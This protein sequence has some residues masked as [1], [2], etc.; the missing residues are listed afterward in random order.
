MST[1]NDY[2]RQFSRYADKTGKPEKSAETGYDRQFS[3]YADKSQPTGNSTRKRSRALRVSLLAAGCVLLSLCAVLA[4]VCIHQKTHPVTLVSDIAS[5]R[6]GFSR[7]GW[8]TETEHEAAT[9]TETETETDSALTFAEEIQTEAPDPEFHPYCTDTT[10]PDNLIEF[11]EVEVNGTILDSTAEY[12]PSSEIS[13]DPGEDYTS[14]EGIVTFRGDNFRNSPSYGF[15]EMS[16][17]T[18]SGI[19]TQ[20][21]GG[22]TYGNAS[23]SGSGWTGQPLMMKWPR[24]AKEHM[25]LYDEAKEDDELVEVIYACMDGYVYFLNLRTGENTRPALARLHVQGKRSP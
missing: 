23:W 22:L 1:E 3:R 4:L 12:A 18:M 9:E 20:T 5:G 25:N 7:Y 6:I 19:W 14:A 2:D 10:N 16:V 17:D 8:R 21:T 11:T 24:A 13:F 15:A